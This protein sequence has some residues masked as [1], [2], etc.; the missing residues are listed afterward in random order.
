MATLDSFQ[1]ENPQAVFDILDRH[2]NLKEASL[3]TLTQTF[4]HE[5]KIGLENYGQ[6][7]G[8]M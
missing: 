1:Q 4:L 7:M 3:A 6:P 8:M 5:F 2:L